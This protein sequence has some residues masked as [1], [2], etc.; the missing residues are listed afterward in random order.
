MNCIVFA[1][2]FKSLSLESLIK[3]EVSRWPTSKF[4]QEAILEEKTQQELYV[5]LKIYAN[6]LLCKYKRFYIL[7][8]KKEQKLSDLEQER[9]DFG[10]FV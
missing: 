4:L 9:W 5:I 3:R 2:L 6:F 10:A 7:L 8:S 1:N